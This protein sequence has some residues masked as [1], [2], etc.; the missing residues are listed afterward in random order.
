[1]CIERQ[2]GLTL[3]ELVVFIVIVGVG[4]AGILSVLNVAA[5][6]SADPLNPRQALA[7]A[8]SLL[9]EVQLKDFDAT[10]AGKACVPGG[11]AQADRSHFICVADYNGFPTSPTTGIYASDGLTPVAGLENYSAR[12][13]VSASGF[14]TGVTGTTAVWLITV[15]VTDPGGS[16]YTLTGY[17]FNY[18]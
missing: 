3:I 14:P 5:R 16:S 7:I 15:T 11:G 1:M 18:G 10:A 13:E 2:R 12:V 4:I 8:E 6:T 17:R 9:E